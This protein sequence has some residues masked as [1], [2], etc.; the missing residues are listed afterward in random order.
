MVFYHLDKGIQLIKVVPK[1]VS[2][3][4][5]SLKKETSYDGVFSVIRILGEQ[6]CGLCGMTIEEISKLKE[7]TVDI[8]ER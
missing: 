3:P 2:N 7:N 6:G 8:E 5:R 1:R 4:F